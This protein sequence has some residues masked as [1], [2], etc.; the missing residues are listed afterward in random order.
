MP[1][2]DS[3]HHPKCCSNHKTNCEL[4]QRSLKNWHK[5]DYEHNN[6]KNIRTSRTLIALFIIQKKS[7]NVHI[8]ILISPLTKYWRY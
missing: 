4:H 3:I 1:G 2:L 6:I 7:P 5:L 8:N